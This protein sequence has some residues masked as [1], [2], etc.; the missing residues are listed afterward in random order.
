M[1]RWHADEEVYK[2]EAIGEKEIKV[3][4]T[5]KEAESASEDVMMNGEAPGAANGPQTVKT[6]LPGMLVTTKSSQK[7]IPMTWS[8]Y[9]AFYAQKFHTPLCEVSLALCCQDTG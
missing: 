7:Q 5:D 2:R 6:R 4:P 3:E 1:D 9:R 8:Q